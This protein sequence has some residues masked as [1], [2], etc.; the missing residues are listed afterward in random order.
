[1]QSTFACAPPSSAMMTMRPSSARHLRLRPMYSP[2]TMSSTTS[3][4][5][6][7]VASSTSLT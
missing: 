3:T 4:P 2:A 6:P 1:M 5:A 7:P